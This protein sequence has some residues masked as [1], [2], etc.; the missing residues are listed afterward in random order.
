[1]RQVEYIAWWVAAIAISAAG[2][3]AAI[4]GRSFIDSVFVIAAL[5]LMYWRG[6]VD[7]RRGTR[8]L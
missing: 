6:Q 1:V 2:H 4:N 5:K 3:V 7:A 8:G